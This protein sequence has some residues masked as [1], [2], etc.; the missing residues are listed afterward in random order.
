MARE[1]LKR[2]IGFL[3]IPVILSAVKKVI[4]TPSLG[5]DGLSVLQE[6]IGRYSWKRYAKSPRFD[7]SGCSLMT[8]QILSLLL[9]IV[10]ST[11]LKDIAIVSVIFNRGTSRAFYPYSFLC[12]TVGTDLSNFDQRRRQNL[13]Q[14]SSINSRPAI[15]PT[16]FSCTPRGAGNCTPEQQTTVVE[17]FHDLGRARSAVRQ[18]YPPSIPG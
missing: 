15:A 12:L 6:N 18:K 8:S 5:Q 2:K 13:L 10:I 16:L 9:S 11:I 7:T 4:S 3:I 17:Y 14:S 1:N